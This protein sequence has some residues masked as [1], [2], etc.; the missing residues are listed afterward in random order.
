MCRLR[1]ARARPA[2]QTSLCV[3]RF[4]SAMWGDGARVAVAPSLLCRGCWYPLFGS[5]SV[6]VH[7]VASVL[8]ARVAF[9]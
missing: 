6:R 9:A 2:S 8:A 1:R 5:D 3:V 7:T 4:A